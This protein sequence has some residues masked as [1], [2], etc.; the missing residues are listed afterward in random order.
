MT[1]EQWR[2]PDPVEVPLVD[3]TQA[4]ASRTGTDVGDRSPA[5]ELGRDGPNTSGPT[6]DIATPSPSRRPPRR[7]GQ[8]GIAALSGLVGLALGVTGTTLVFRLSSGDVGPDAADLPAAST[9][10]I[11][12]PPTLAPVLDPTDRD[13]S[14]GEPED[15][16]GRSPQ[17]VV[18]ATVITL[19]PRPDVELDAVSA[20]YLLSDGSLAELDTP[21]SRRSVTEY[22]AGSGGFRQTVTITNDPTT[23][24]YR[25]DFD[26]GG[27]VQRVVVDLIGDAT[28][29]SDGSGNW[30]VVPNDEVVDGTDAP[31][32]ATFLR[33]L[34]LGPIRS[35]TADRW[36]LT[37]PN[38]LVDPPEGGDALREYI[39][40]M[41]ADA[42][43]EWARYAL[44]PSSEAP[45]VGKGTLIGF[46]V[47]VSA[48]GSIRIVTGSSDFGTTTERITH[49][50]EMLD[51]PPEIDLPMV[52]RTVEKSMSPD[53]DT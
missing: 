21:R 26:F 11:T 52:D 15:S 28:Y 22:V 53:S 12:V 18:A 5:G 44:G 35:D 25:L 1:D 7:V 8:R 29:V 31:D 36:M 38:P 50:I 33:R 49:R 43:P 32:M 40:V 42:V 48:D 51:E 19:A 10:S 47:Y 2:R 23:Q 4:G 24:R 37:R 30:S 34:Q 17:E 39:V 46:A 9:D 6:H 3:I 27:P 41:E 14:T 16:A 13:I 20:G 45:P